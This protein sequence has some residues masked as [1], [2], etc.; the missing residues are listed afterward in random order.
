M[1]HYQDLSFG[2]PVTWDSSIH[3]VPPLVSITSLQL[4]ATILISPSLPVPSFG[5][6]FGWRTNEVKW[7][8]Q[9]PFPQ[10]SILSLTRSLRGWRW[11]SNSARGGWS[12][13]G[14]FFRIW[15]CTP[16]TFNTCF[17]C[18]Y[19]FVLSW[20]EILSSPCWFSVLKVTSETKTCLY[21]SEMRSGINSEDVYL[22]L[23]LSITGCMTLGRS[24]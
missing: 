5:H 19:T 3:H 16:R 23:D 1:F 2:C 11:R 22:I 17:I 14:V 15:D 21:V 12:L 4:N 6:R 9:S 18:C 7:Y 10:L 20:F 13:D 8:V 24:L